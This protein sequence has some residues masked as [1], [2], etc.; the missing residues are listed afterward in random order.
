MTAIH[1]R[2]RWQV[3]IEDGRI[4]AA[5]PEGD[6]A[7]AALAELHAVVIETN[8]SGPFG[9]DCWWQLHQDASGVP[10][11]VFPQSAVGAENAV[12]ALVELPGFDHMAMLA[13]MGSTGN[14]RFPVWERPHPG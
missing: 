8:D 5:R 3:W 2:W 10:D 4:V 6:R 1:N 14:A 9:D 13:A 12:R 11:C 7:Q